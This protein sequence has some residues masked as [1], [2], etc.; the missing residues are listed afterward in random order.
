MIID[1][2]KEGL[3]INQIIGQRNEVVTIDGDLIIP[4]IKPDIISTIHTHGIVCCYKK[5][6]LEG[7]VR[8]DGVIYLY[9]TYLADDT[10]RQH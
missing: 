9:I 8:L 1:T 6:V 7:K 5:E 4:D 2:T 10:V 3:C